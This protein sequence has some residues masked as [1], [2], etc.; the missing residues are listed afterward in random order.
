M[1]KYDEMTRGGPRRRADDAAG[2]D[3]N[4][5]AERPSRAISGAPV[6]GGATS[7]LRELREKAARCFRL[8]NSLINNS[9]REL[10]LRL[11]YEIER[12]IAQAEGF[13]EAQ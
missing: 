5:G 10:L 13:H 8:A 1:V 11:G 9:D 3:E 6:Q 4:A 7:E 2:A 12:R